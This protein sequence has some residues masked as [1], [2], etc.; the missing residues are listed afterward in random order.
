MGD[1]KNKEQILID[2]AGTM[3]GIYMIEQLKNKEV[4]L[5]KNLVDGYAYSGAD[6][7]SENIT[8]TGTYTLTGK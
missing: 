3:G 4:I 1:N 2:M 5:K 7:E 8:E 6:N